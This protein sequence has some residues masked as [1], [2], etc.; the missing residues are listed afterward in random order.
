MRASGLSCQASIEYWCTPTT[1]SPYISIFASYELET[2]HLKN[3]QDYSPK[4]HG[5]SV[6]LDYWWSNHFQSPYHMN[7]VGFKQK[8]I[9]W[10]ELL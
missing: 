6:W 4:Q 2:M 5:P 1:F 9:Q 10:D 8:E 7:Q 3:C